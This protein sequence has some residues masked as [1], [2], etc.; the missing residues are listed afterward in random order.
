MGE[1]QMVVVDR[2]G[3]LGQDREDQILHQETLVPDRE[4]Q[5]LLREILPVVLDRLLLL[6][7][8]GG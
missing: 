3:I 8:V 5:H 1:V 7:Q 2:M 6:L 4:D